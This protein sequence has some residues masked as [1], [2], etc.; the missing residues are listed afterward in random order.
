MLLPGTA[1]GLSGP[2]LATALAPSDKAVQQVNV[3]CSSPQYET[4]PGALNACN[5]CKQVVDK[6]KKDFAKVARQTVANDSALANTGQAGVGKA[7]GGVGSSNLSSF[8]GDQG[9]TTVGSNTEAARGKNA[10]AG[11]TQFQKCQQ[12]VDNACNSL[13]APDRENADKMSQACQDAANKTGSYAQDKNSNSEGMGDLSKLMDAASK[14]LG[15]AQGLMPKGGGPSGATAP[16]PNS[17]L[18]SGV[19][20]PGL[21]IAEASKSDLG[22][23]TST[24]G[25]P[26]AQSGIA[27]SNLAGAGANGVHTENA[28]VGSANSSGNSSSNGK[29]NFT[30][31]SAFGPGGESASVGATGGGS[32]GGA[33]GGSF[34]STG[35]SR[36]GDAMAAGGGAGTGAGD[37][38]YAI[39]PGSGRPMMG[40]KPSKA[41]LSDLEET[42][43]TEEA[44]KLEDLG[45]REPA[46]E[47]AGGDVAADGET[48]F[49]Q[50][51]RKYS[52]LKGA[53]RI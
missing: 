47:M 31:A 3:T 40:L 35:S 2:T 29:N 24:T 45:N 7:V 1:F 50:V 44:A 22:A 34:N 36:M 6:W 15:M 14:G 46:S 26:A 9:N 23:G 43:K 13:F 51:K 8:R 18:G 42:P 4:T 25:D 5:S 30:G 19:S 12:E 10:T 27:F 38:A 49:K 52:S 17:D 53:G 28:G 48:L 41:D 21:Q 16:T 11:Q 33:G 39:N 37:A 20:D 32:K